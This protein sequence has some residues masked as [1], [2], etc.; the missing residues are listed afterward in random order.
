LG[1]EFGTPHFGDKKINY[2]VFVG[3]DGAKKPINIIDFLP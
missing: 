1:I 2:D 3:Y